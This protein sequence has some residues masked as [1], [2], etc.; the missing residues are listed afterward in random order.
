MNMKLSSFDTWFLAGIFLF[1]IVSK[2]IRLDSPDQ[3]YFDEGVYYIPAARDYLQGVFDA[4]FE[5]PPLAKLFMSAGIL[6]FGD[7][8][9]GWR[10]PEVLVGSLG[11]IFIYLLAKKMFPPSSTR[12]RTSGDKLA[13][14]DLREILSERFVPI[15]AA[16]FLTFE[17]SWFVNS[18][19][20]NLEIYVATFSL[21]AAYFFWNFY[22][23]EAF[24][25]L[26][27]AGVFFG[28]AIASKWNGL[29][30]L[31]FVSL[32]YLWHRRRKII[33]ASIKIFLIVLIATG[34][35]LGSYSFYLTR[36]S[37]ADFTNLQVKMYTYHTL[38]FPEKI[39]ELN[40]GVDR[41]SSYYTPWILLF[42]P[43][44]PYHGESFDG[45]VRS[46][47]FLYNPAIFWGGLIAI[48]L[49]LRKLSKSPEKVFL[50]GS[51]AAFWLPLVVSPRYS[52]PYYL[53]P[54]IPFIILLLA[55]VIRERLEDRKFF[56]IG[57]LVA[58][59]VIFFFYYPLL[60]N[61]TVSP[62]YLKMLIGISGFGP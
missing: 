44:Y 29:F 26:G 55:K 50:I 35:Y 24:K 59:V 19:I 33:P 58:V 18:R 47:L 42:N 6:L 46:I 12:Q 41:Y 43:P 56:L 61:L 32:F 34:I 2:L 7:N 31:A 28:L 37:L 52:L 4:N 1:N 36:H 3:G 57:F 13:L 39:K 45:E 20:A 22:Q 16:V 40:P 9:W 14:S 53:L 38:N 23:N 49:S 11:V 25:Y 27:L 54:A 17:F 51:S 62:W 8:P 60:S 48:G 30:L 15:L 5:H 10:I 21:A